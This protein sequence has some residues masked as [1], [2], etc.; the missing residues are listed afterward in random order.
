MNDFLCD[1]S[2]AGALDAAAAAAAAAVDG[3]AGQK[4]F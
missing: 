1:A 3:E 2:V 4:S